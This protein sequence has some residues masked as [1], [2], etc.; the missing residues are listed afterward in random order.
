[1]I[2][3]VDGRR[4]TVEREIRLA[5]VGVGHLGREHARVASALPGAC[6][7]GLYDH[8]EGRADE[9]A[10]EFGL[11]V[12]ADLESVADRAE[13]VVVAT[14]TA[15]HAEIAR[16]FLARG[17]DVLIEKPITVTLAEAD[18]L[19]ALA[20]A[21]GRVIAVG[22]VER[23]NPAVEAVFRLLSQPRFV[24]V[25]R[26]GAFTGRSVDVDVVRDLMI[27][28]LQ[29]VR[30]LVGRPVADVQAAGLPVL[31]PQ[32]DIAS[33]RLT[34]EGGCVASLTASRVSPEKVRKFRV[35]APSLY[36][37]IDMLARSATAFRLSRE[38]GTPEV[39]SVALPVEKEEPLRHELDD[40]VRCVR[41]RARP[42]VSGETGRDALA[43]ANQVLEAI[44][45]HRRTVEGAPG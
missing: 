12:L 24:E 6:V 30:E 1:V 36:I 44:E 32:L 21:S 15:N 38:R 43:L 26:L 17:R 5:V 29:I 42:R 20:R 39:L 33:A 27:H 8:R 13:A 45:A 10:R 11:E 35:F 9:V 14:P 31:T 22:H 16:F 18:D 4:S 28:D 37:S 25:H 2:S 7:V 23:Y 41:E 34:F 19:L 40:F 3:G